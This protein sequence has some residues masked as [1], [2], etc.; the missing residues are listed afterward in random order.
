MKN[1]FI[2]ILFL[3]S[4]SLIYSQS[5][6]IIRNNIE[7]GM[8]TDQVISRENDGLII[9]T[10]NMLGYSTTINDINYSLYYY[11][12]GNKLF[13][14]TYILEN[15][16]DD[17]NNYINVYQD[18]KN[19]FIKKYGPISTNEENWKNDL[20]K[21]D[22]DDYGTAVKTGNLSYLTQWNINE[23]IIRLTLIGGK[24]NISFYINYIETNLYN[25][26]QGIE[27]K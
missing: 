13:N 21:E 16:F 14:V 25:I 5:P 4:Y 26:A 7:F 15:T 19:K 6:F 11:F 3:L 27:N 17:D 8:T 24:Y 18:I 20:Y 12:T 23:N 9:A 1:L 22:P 10:N 2:I